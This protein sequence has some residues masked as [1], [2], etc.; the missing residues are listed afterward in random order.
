MVE[1]EDAGEIIG[2]VFRIRVEAASVF[3]LS[4][5]LNPN[6]SSVSLSNITSV[7]SIQL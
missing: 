5:R 4:E 3:N 2:D 1:G 6:P 7:S